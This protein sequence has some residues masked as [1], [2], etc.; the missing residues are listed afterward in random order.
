MFLSKHDKFAVSLKLILKTR[1][2]PLVVRLWQPAAPSPAGVRP[3]ASEV[4]RSEAS[5]LI[6][7]SEP[8]TGRVADTPGAPSPQAHLTGGGCR[9]GDNIPCYRL[10]STPTQNASS[11]GPGF[12]FASHRGCHFLSAHR[13]GL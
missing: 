7:F 12:V 8:R 5:A 13:A 1:S 2:S 4:V 6:P 9:F 3:R 10:P 11:E